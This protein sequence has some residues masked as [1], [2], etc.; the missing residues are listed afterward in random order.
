M[1]HPVLHLNILEMAVV[2]VCLKQFGFPSWAFLFPNSGA[3]LDFIQCVVL[4]LSLVRF[5]FW[6]YP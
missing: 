6:I 5:L 2:F 3:S 1:N 4:H